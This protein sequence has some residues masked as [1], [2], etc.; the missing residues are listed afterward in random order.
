MDKHIPSHLIPFL[1][2][3]ERQNISEMEEVFSIKQDGM[4]RTER[5]AWK[6]KI[7][8]AII[9][10]GSKANKKRRNKIMTRE[11]VKK[12]LPLIQAFVEGK[13]IQT[14]NGSK[15][16][17]IDSDKNQLIL[18]SV[19]TYQDCFRIKSEPSYR[20]FRNVEECWQEML[21]HAPFGIMS[22]KNSKDYMSFMSLNDEGC[23]F[24]GYEGENFESAFDDIQ[25]ADG[26]PFGIKE[27]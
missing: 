24:C 19:V 10:V 12:A 16:I 14:K 7:S 15:W 4:T 2:E 26:T 3:Y 9:K 13:T 1:D 17:D 6:R 21:K 27:D 11:Q 22:S 5:R 8:K 20:P 18:D 23:D 25:F